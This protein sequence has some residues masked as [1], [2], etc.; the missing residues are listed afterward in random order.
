M[1]GQACSNGEDV[2]VEYNIFGGK[3][4]FGEQLVSAFANANFVFVVS[5]LTL[6]IECHDDSGSTVLLNKLGSF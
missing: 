1:F 6:F 2:R 4:V 3:T 5:R